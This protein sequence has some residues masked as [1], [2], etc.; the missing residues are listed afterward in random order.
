MELDWKEP[1]RRCP[2][3]TAFQNLEPQFSAD[4]VCSFSPRNV[5]MG[6]IC[7]AFWEVGGTRGFQ[8]RHCFSLSGTFH[9]CL[10][11]QSVGFPLPGCL[12]AVV[13]TCLSSGCEWGKHVSISLKKIRQNKI[14]HSCLFTFP[15]A[16]SFL[17]ETSALAQS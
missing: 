6:I 10:S 16:I 14:L 3:S 8:E 1:A 9:V 17:W 11:V 4:S 15:S 7:F 5:R 13:D 2:P 12:Q